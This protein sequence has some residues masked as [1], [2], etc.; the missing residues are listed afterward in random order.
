MAKSLTILGSILSLLLLSFFF[1]H[2]EAHAANQSVE[3]VGQYAK[4]GAHGYPA[5]DFSTISFWVKIKT[6][7]QGQAIFS[8]NSFNDSI[9]YRPAASCSGVACIDW[10]DPGAG[11]ANS[12]QKVETPVADGQ[13]HSVAM[14]K[15]PSGNWS[16]WIDGVVSSTRP[17][18]GYTGGAGDLFLGD[19]NG[20]ADLLVD[21]LTLY[22][23]A[24]STSTMESLANYCNNPQTNLISQ[25]NFDGDWTDSG[26]DGWNATL[27]AGADHWSNDVPTCET[28]PTTSTVRIL[29]P[30]SGVHYGFPFQSQIVAAVDSAATGTLTFYAQHNLIQSTIPMG[31][32]FPGNYWYNY[33]FQYQG[34]WA[35][36]ATFKEPGHATSTSDIVQ[37]TVGGG[38]QLASGTAPFASDT[39]R[40]SFC[41]TFGAS[42]TAFLS[43]S[44]PNI[45]WHACAF[46]LWAFV[47]GQLPI[48]ELEF[49]KHKPFS[50]FFELTDTI[51][52]VID[53]AAT[54]TSS[55]D[56]NL[57]GLK[58]RPIVLHFYSEDLRNGIGSSTLEAIRPYDDYILWGLVLAYT[59][60][61]G[62]LAASIL[63]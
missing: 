19:N 46:S 7:T 54:A 49:K 31:D 58:N 59:V 22:S 6:P 4:D 25:W 10:Y 48:P 21:R 18:A 23:T 29:N 53:H 56:L 12:L 27:Q 5:S 44:F 62:V 51:T 47:P 57:P 24:L 11:G 41:D 50:T 35:V 13:W 55:F 32:V 8:P 36:W 9:L 37:F 40:T 33:N 42:S 20:S 34:D 61:L 38:Y 17:T 3:L 45:A 16:G 28:Q 15:D 30:R 63:T 43:F 60:G 2:S 14:R 52:Y 1:T 39:L 26:P